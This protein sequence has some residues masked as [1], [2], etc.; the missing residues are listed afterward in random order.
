MRRQF[1]KQV[2]LGILGI[3]LMPKLVFSNDKIIK[4]MR[5]KPML[6]HNVGGFERITDEDWNNG[7]YAQPK[8]DGVRCLIQAEGL[9]PYHDSNPVSH[10]FMVKAYSRTG[11]EW[12][13]IDHILCLLYTSPSPRDS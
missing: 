6:A 1:I 13:N 2:G 11:K 5:K 4:G 8:L 10:G 3:S 9:T 7:L 12:K